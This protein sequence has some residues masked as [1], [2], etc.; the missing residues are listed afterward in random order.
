MK[1]AGHFHTTSKTMDKLTY[2][3]TLSNLVPGIVFLWSLPTLGPFSSD[4]ILVLLSGNTIVD[5]I[6]VVAVSY[7]VGHLLQFL[8]KYSIEPLVKRIF[9][10]GQFFSDVFL[11]SAYKQCPE[12]QLSRY[13]SLAESKLGFSQRDLAVLLDPELLSK[14]TEKNKAI[15]L[16]RA[17]YRAVDAK[18]Q[19]ES[20]AEKAHVQNTFYSFFRNLSALFLIVGLLDLAAVIFKPGVLTD[21]VPL[22]LLLNFALAGIFLI[23]AKQRGELYVRGLFWSYL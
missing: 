6:L 7:M 12:A 19:D 23:R 4:A 17:I 16:S 10:K 18:T 5:S 14:E 1:E 20:L 8:S 2:Y 11:V 22:V 13:V 9:W 21:T 3:D 15:E